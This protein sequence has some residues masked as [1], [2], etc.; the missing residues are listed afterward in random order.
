MGVSIYVEPD[1][2]VQWGVEMKKINEDANDNL[3]SFVNNVKNLEGS[4]AG[5][6]ADGFLTANESFFKQ[7]TSYHTKMCDLDKLLNTVVETMEKE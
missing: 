6:S 7:A 4:W 2:L 3:T 1:A 5:L